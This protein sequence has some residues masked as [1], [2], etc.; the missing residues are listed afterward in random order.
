M[1]SPLLA[2]ID[3]QIEKITYHNA[4]NGYTVAKALVGGRHEQIT[5]V[6]HLH[7]VNPGD[8]LRLEGQWQRHPKFGE[9]F[10]VTSYKPTIP[11]TARGIEQYL[12]SGLIK[13]IGPVMA[14]RLVS[15]FGL[16]T[17]TIIET[18]VEKLREVEGIGEKRLDMIR[19]AWS[20][21]K[22][23]RELMLFLHEHGVSAAHGVRVFRQYGRDSIR[24]LREEPY[25][26]AT[27]I[28]GIGFLT[29]DRIA[30]KM[31]IPKE[32]P[33]RA[34]AGILYVLRQL[35]EEGHVC[36][37]YE[38]LVSESA[39]FLGIDRHLVETALA[40]LASGKNIT[41]ESSGNEFSGASQRLVYLT[42]LYVSEV[43]IARRI[44]KLLRS[45]KKKICAGPEDVLHW[46][47]RT[48]EIQL[49][50]RQREA[51]KEALDKNL[52]VITGGPGTGKT[53]VIHAIIRIYEKGGRRVLLAAPTG[54]AAKRMTEA[55]GHEAKTIHRLLEFSPK[56]GTFKRNADNPLE[57]DLIIIDEASMVDMT[58]MSHFLSAVRDGTSVI[59]VG[60]VD[61]LPS[62]GPG[63]VLRDVIDSGVIP[64]VRLTEIFRQAR[65][66]LIV[67]NAHRINAGEMPIMTQEYRDSQDFYFF[68]AEDPDKIFEKVIE[69]C[70][71]KIPA[72]F[73]FDPLEDIQVMTPMHRG[74]IGAVRLNDALQ[75]HL[76]P[77]TGE[78][79]RRGRI[80]KRGDKVMQIRNNY[81]KEVFNGDIG[82]IAVIDRE[83]QEVVVDY[84]GRMV[85]YDF[86]ELDELVIAYAI[87]VH[88]S[89]G[90]EYPVVV[91]PIHT[92]HFMLLQRNLLYTAITRGKKLVILVGTK[93]A[94]AIAVSNDKTQQRYTMLK[95][96][97]LAEETS[98]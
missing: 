56:D 57:T 86:Q 66:S 87:T 96:R 26:L 93:R 30:E 27:D 95:E 20:E 17:L 5:V 74:V 21:Q 67:V 76:N 6:G 15:A 49:A 41:I 65:E 92:Q 11:S 12:G 52:L 55:T 13:G 34:E 9:Q 72:K 98:L 45:P 51:V 54:R 37:P 1:A 33:L 64:L 88:K 29:A 23:T 44:Q 14:K 71:D 85:P 24:I 79:V 2:E 46:A 36:Y 3:A 80:F 10:L 68:P 62:V 19:T 42:H 83:E 61:Q 59:F 63:N 47:Q 8:V 60:D 4:E 78:F 40:K 53:T 84:D 97:L 91:M 16:E 48:L 7:S 77:E 35:S 43:T 69:L 58:L 22:E 94:I 50:D 90:S 39:S 31:N 73:G 32:S 25:R 38:R 18:N 82:K 70:R 75:R 28:V 81:E 89:Q